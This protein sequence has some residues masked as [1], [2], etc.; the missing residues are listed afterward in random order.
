M[1]SNPPQPELL[2]ALGRA[3]RGLSALFWGAPL[4]LLSYVQTAR[5][6]LFRPL[7]WMSIGPALLAT[8][9]VWHG[10]SQLKF[11]QPQE[12]IWRRVL[13]RAHFFAL[14]NFGLVPFLAY[15]RDRGAS[16]LNSASVMLLG[17][18][19]LCLLFVLNLLLLRLAA[20][21][22]DEAL[23]ME[24]RLFTR[25]NRAVLVC[26]PCLLAVLAVLRRVPGIPPSV[27]QV[28]AILDHFSPW[29]TLF[30][31]LLPLAMTMALLWKMK[32]AILT[33]IIEGR[34]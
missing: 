8:A 4:I 19:S 10:V 11:F 31:V 12:R 22:P 23:R 14:V 18:S 16:P 28:L 3:A 30:F 17:A 21:L 20:M 27:A 29:L 6:D 34:R 5:T 32:E 26:L 24:A 1:S 13:D 15:Y 33:S 9:L 2:R 25:F 7:G